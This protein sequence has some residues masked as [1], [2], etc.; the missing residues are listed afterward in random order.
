MLHGVVTGRIPGD[1]VPDGR[2]TLPGALRIEVPPSLVLTPKGRIV[3]SIRLIRLEPG[4]GGA[5]R[6]EGAGAGEAGLEAVFR[7]V[8]PP[9]FAK[10]ERS[11]PP[12]GL[13]T[14]LGPEA[15]EVLAAVLARGE[16]GEPGGPREPA[17][18]A[19]SDRGC[20]TGLRA[21]A[22]SEG[23]SFEQGSAQVIRSDDVA[24]EAFDLVGP[25]PMVEY[26]I[27]ALRALG[28][29]E[30]PLDYWRALRIAR[31]RPEFGE[32]VDETVL[33]PEAGLERRMVD[34]SKGCYTGQEVIVRIRDRGKV[35]RHLR[36]VICPPET[37]PPERF[38]PGTLPAVGTPLFA[39]GRERPVGEIRSAAP[40]LVTGGGGQRGLALALVRHEIEPPATLHLGEPGGGTVTVHALH[41]EGWLFREPSP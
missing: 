19:E 17:E 23:L 34:A 30:A 25:A 27:E 4:E 29:A 16:P 32:E 31:G 3:A 12:L 7:Q 5:L 11:D 13:L 33:P 40:D 28:V 41:P 24:L 20:L 37:F 1:P 8:L 18:P 36:G 6:I 26:W 2:A 35:N 22:P 10:V 15:A 9:R 14:V 38:P 21:L 39:D